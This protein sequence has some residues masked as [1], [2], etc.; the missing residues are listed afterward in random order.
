MALK[1]TEDGNSIMEPK[2]DL[3]LVQVQSEQEFLAAV[4]GIVSG[5]VD[6]TDLH[7]RPDN[8]TSNTAFLTDDQRQMIA[9]ALSQKWT[10]PEFKVKNFIG[11]A[12]IT[13][14]AK[15]KQYLLELNTR[16]SAVE[17][18]E[19]EVQKVA[20]EIQLQKELQAETPSVAQKKIFALE[21]LK[22][23]RVLK[24]NIMR[25]RDCYFERA[26]YLKLIEQF[27]NS[28]QGYLEDGRRLYDVMGDPE[29]SERLE[30]HYWTLR[31]AK[32]TALDMIAYGRA[33]VGNMEAV[34]MLEPDQQY[35]VMHLA[36]DY[37]VRNE[38]RTNGIL[39]AVNEHVQ[40]L[41]GAEPTEL[42]KELYITNQGTS[43]VPPVQIGTR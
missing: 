7:Y 10:V 1:T 15:L 38:H 42:S 39:S 5:K 28:D 37:F 3:N 24:K 27:N 40:Q 41:Q 6:L 11:N 8:L 21:I 18:M 29:E 34:T 13:P 16:E 43:N 4:Q 36:C 31:L 12:Q 35:E 19:Y 23:Q 2:A 17:S 14:Y 26:M 30:K 20:L 9:D 33:G 22:L 32:Q 25:L